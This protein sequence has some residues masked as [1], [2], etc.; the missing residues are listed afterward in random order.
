M[1]HIRALTRLLI[2]FIDIC[3][4]YKIQKPPTGACN[5]LSIALVG[6]IIE[7]TAMGRSSFQVSYKELEQYSQFAKAKELQ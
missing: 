4:E 3:R 2:N 7:L 6:I 1:E 5:S